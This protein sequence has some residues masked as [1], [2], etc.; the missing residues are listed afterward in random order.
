MLTYRIRFPYSY[1]GYTYVPRA[2]S[3][4]ASNRAICPACRPRR[5]PHDYMQADSPVAGRFGG[6]MAPSSGRSRSAAGGRGGGDVF[7]QQGRRRG[8]SSGH[9]YSGGARR[10]GSSSGRN[11]NRS[12]CPKDDDLCRELR[13]GRRR[14]NRFRSQHGLGQHS[15]RRMSEDEVL[16][17]FAAGRRGG[18]RG[19]AGVGPVA[20]VC[21]PRA[22][23]VSVERLRP[24]HRCTCPRPDLSPACNCSTPLYGRHRRVIAHRCGC[25]QP[26]EHVR[27]ACR[28]QRC[29]Y[30]PVCRQ[31]IFR[32]VCQSSC[33]WSRAHTPEVDV[34]ASTG[35]VAVTA[36]TDLVTWQW[37]ETLLTSWRD[38]D[39]QLG[40]G[41][42]WQWQAVQ[43]SAWQWPSA[44]W[45]WQGTL[46][47]T[48]DSWQWP[49]ASWQWQGALQ[50]TQ[51]SWQWP[52]VSWEWQGALQGT[53][54]SWQ[55]PGASWQWQGA[56]QGTQ[57]NWQ[58]PSASWQWQGVEDSWQW[59]EALGSWQWQGIHDS[60]WQWQGAFG[61][62]QWQGAFGSW[63]W[64]RTNWQWQGAFGSLQWRQ[65]LL[66]AG[67]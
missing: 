48:Q 30:Q 43:T 33:T 53:Q 32:Q 35:S 51:D 34:I 28:C 67:H 15:G 66:Q 46:Q 65:S 44:S 38:T 4:T 8:L 22:V 39:W 16:R 64:R 21:S 24:T 20:W 27:S 60:S 18:G 14:Y 23:N 58:W 62:W 7:Q 47:G 1:L 11:L 63:Q 42:T 25:H 3:L 9:L 57:D 61:S 45:Q 19:Q 5:D 36:G 49:G 12:R 13:R 40:L 6:G 17:L 54:D 26:D 52:S 31:P 50:G 55:W 2:L 37:P 41:D 59:Q 29:F 56:L 10:R